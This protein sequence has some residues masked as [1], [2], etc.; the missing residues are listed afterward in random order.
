MLGVISRWV[1]LCG[2]PVGGTRR[3]RGARRFARQHESEHLIV[4]LVS[5]R[6]LSRSMW[7]E[8]FAPGGAR[9]GLVGC[10]R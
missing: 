6:V 9:F 8:H 5:R 7:V 1:F 10:R 2:W 3:D 4:V